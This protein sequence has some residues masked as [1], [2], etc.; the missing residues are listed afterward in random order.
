MPFNPQSSPN[1]YVPFHPTAHSTSRPQHPHFTHSRSL[2]QSSTPPSPSKSPKKNLGLIVNTTAASGNLGVSPT[3]PRRMSK[4]KG[5]ETPR[6]KERERSLR[7]L[8]EVGSATISLRVRAVEGLEEDDDAECSTQLPQTHPSSLPQSQSYPTRLLSTFISRPNKSRRERSNSLH[9]PTRPTSLDR[10][11]YLP[12]YSLDKEYSLPRKEK[13]KDKDGRT[14]KLELGLGDDFNTS[15]GEAMRLGN[16]GKEL[17]LPKEA[18]IMLSQAKEQIG[19]ATKTKQ[20]RKGSMG[21]GLFKESHAA[22][23]IDLKKPEEEAIEEEEDDHSGR[24]SSIKIRSRT[25]TRSSRSTL[26][27]EPTIVGPSITP[28]SSLPIRGSRQISDRGGL[29]PVGHSPA[30]TSAG[31]ASPQQQF[32]DLEEQFDEDDESWTTTSTES[33]TSDPEEDGRD[34]MSEVDYGSE[35]REEEE[36]M[37]VPLQPFSHAVGGHSSIY[38]FTRR[39]VC[40]PLVS[41]ENLFYEEV[42]RLAPALLAFIPRYLGVMVVNYR[43]QRA[44][45]EGSTTPLD[46][47]SAA[48][49]YPSHPSTLAAASRS[50]NQ[51]AMLQQA[52]TGATNQS[53]TSN[54]SKEDVEIPE[55]A[56]DFNRHVVPDWLFN[57]E[58]KGKGR[59]GR[60]WETSEEE[61]SRRT[62]RPSSARSQEFMRYGSGSPGSSWQSSFGISPNLRASGLGSPALPKA[63]PEH[64]YAGP[65]TPVPSP[66]TSF[67]HRQGHLHHIA[68]SPI[69]PYRSQFNNSS[70]DCHPGYS[71]PHPF[72]GTGSTTVNTKLKDHV[73]AAI[74]KKLRKRGIGHRQDD[75]ADDEGDDCS[76]SVSSRRRGRRQLSG[77]GSMDL[78]E[79]TEANEGIRRTQSGGVLTEL[80]NKS[81]R[82]GTGREDT[83]RVREDSAERGMFDME[84]E[85]EPPLEM[86]RKAKV[87][88]GNGLHPMTAVRADSHS[89]HLA[90]DQPPF[91]PSRP[92][93]PPSSAPSSVTESSRLG[94]SRS[95]ASQTVPNSPS[96]PPDDNPRQELF[97]FMED[98]TGRLKHPCV[99][100]LKM[101]T[102]QYG[103][104]A[105]PLKKRSQRKKCDATTSRTLGVRM[106][107]MQVWNN[108]TQS[109]VSQNK[110]VGREIKTPDF[111]SVIRSY[112]SDGD[113]LLIDHIPVIVQ[114]LHDLAA[115]IHQLDGFRFYGCS[116]LFIYDGDKDTQ[117]TY[118]RQMSS[119]KTLDALEEEDE[120]EI[121]DMERAPIQVDKEA[122]ANSNRQ[123]E[124]SATVEK[125]KT[126]KNGRSRSVDK[127]A[128]H[129]SRSR[130]RGRSP[131]QST[132]T[133]QHRKLRGEVNI[134]VVDFAHTTTGRDF[135]PF[136]S[137]HV[138]PP[139]LGKGYDTQFDEA[140]GM[141]MARFPPKHPGKPDMGF[142]FGLKSICESL[143][144]I[145]GAE[146]GEEEELVAKKNA[147]IFDLVFA[148]GA[149]LST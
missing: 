86:K 35:E 66:S 32:E 109:F 39:A 56:L 71:S 91:G 113:R 108:D 44:I 29:S 107:G 120:E 95:G 85:D 59:N 123:P 112:L 148:N 142:L 96:V 8:G 92:A 34:W 146:K 99:L 6:Q 55:V 3:S 19:S 132:H 57:W 38:K 37:T 27:S 103:Y 4:G 126:S 84:V 23:K 67:Q 33:F 49:P 124:G 62:M 47:P 111:T 90:E 137:D 89:T 9:A 82:A 136:P 63:I 87:P 16:E 125:D 139:N 72:G 50:D 83:R 117:D 42:E 11:F 70:T 21:M 93:I 79:P 105:T 80:R 7:E 68:S 69:L 1:K 115:I 81:I 18:L 64:Q 129:S 147:D 40:K 28:A 13:G 97:I 131:H 135:V 60:P 104:D 110:Y 24:G 101:G 36:R 140:T 54:H 20:G 78:R 130:S 51:R 127:S 144:E 2:T 65:S 119:G 94:Q 88:L 43:R 45:Q 114:K 30:A 100:D 133:H 76:Y 61:G 102:R 121:T 145:W 143:A 26:V 116:L 128:R 17:P 22:A 41:H 58:E 46:S 5:R 25:E 12:H 134:R 15:F 98:L 14:P 52:L 48:S 75:E 141:V 53:H 122:W 10:S 74:L 73:F 118:S 31:L 106:C 138:D 149:D 77:G